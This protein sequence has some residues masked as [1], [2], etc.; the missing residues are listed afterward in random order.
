MMNRMPRF[1]KRKRKDEWLQPQV[2]NKV[3]THLTQIRTV[4]EILSVSKQIE[5]EIFLGLRLSKG[6]D[7]N[8]LKNKYNTDIYQKFKNIF[9]KYIKYN[10]M[11]KTD[12]G[13]RLTINGIL[14]S[15]EILCDFIE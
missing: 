7:F 9:D 8:Y 15:N 3:D 14:I 2:Q 4:H 6:I 13:V 11:Q 12:K 10:F 5:E 1:D